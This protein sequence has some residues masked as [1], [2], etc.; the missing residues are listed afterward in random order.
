MKSLKLK[1]WF[2]LIFLIIV[3]GLVLFFSAGTINYWQVWVFLILFTVSV[4]A[5][6]LYLMRKDPALLERRT[7][8]GPLAEKE[9][10]QKII[11]SI[12]SLA[13]L[14][15]LFVPALDRRFIWSDV[16]IYL[17][18]IGDAL[19]VVGIYIVFRV[20][21]ENTFTS[22][23]IE[24]GKEQ[25]VISTGPYAT[26][27]HP[28]YSG[29]LIMLIGIP[30]ALGSWWGLLTF[31]P[32]VAVLTWRLFDEEKFLVKNLPGYTDYCVT[33]RSRLIPGIF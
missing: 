26:V 28:M 25:K 4:S 19:V 24:V 3:M 1:A 30:I 14:A 8:A 10:M 5:I 31:I 15:V 29:A 6:T 2:G 9:I 27:R 21:K 17:V 13:F 22:A 18:V 33:V 7:S 16:P 11:Q 23:T 32:F 20:F 12:A